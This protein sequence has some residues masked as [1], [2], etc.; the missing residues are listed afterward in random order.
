MIGWGLLMNEKL[1]VFSVLSLFHD[2]NLD[3]KLRRWVD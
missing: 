1:W 2:K 3:I